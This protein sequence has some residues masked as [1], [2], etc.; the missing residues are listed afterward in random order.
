MKK[1]SQKLPKSDQSE[2]FPSFLDIESRV[3]TEYKGNIYIGKDK[4]DAT[5]RS[6]LK[7]EA[8]NL[9]VS[10]LWEILNA[11]VINEAYRLGLNQSQN[12]DNVL[13]AK[14]LYE[15]SKFMLN[16]IHTLAKDA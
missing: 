3:F 8:K 16:V 4:I 2:D 13:Y 7:D 6:V 12:W 1:K 10:R 5:L 15:W 14:A 9:Q 11:S